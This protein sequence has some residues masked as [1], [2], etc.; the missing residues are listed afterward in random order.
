MNLEYRNVYSITKRGVER[1]HMFSPERR[2]ADISADRGRI[3][4]ETVCRVKR[5]YEPPSIVVVHYQPTK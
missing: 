3:G 2:W 1:G 5:W 4:V